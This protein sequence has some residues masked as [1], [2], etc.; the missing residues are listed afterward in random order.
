M[1]TR[2]DPPQRGTDVCLGGPGTDMFVSCETQV[3]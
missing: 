1:S 2:W 3:Q